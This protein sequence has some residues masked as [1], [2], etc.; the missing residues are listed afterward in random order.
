[1]PVAKIKKKTTAD[2][3]RLIFYKSTK[4]IKETKGMKIR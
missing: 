4:L 1:M 2:F 3:Q